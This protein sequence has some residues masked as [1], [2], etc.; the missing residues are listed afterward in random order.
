MLSNQV[1]G[2]SVPWWGSD[3]PSPAQGSIKVLWE[4]A[5]LAPLSGPYLFSA[6]SSHMPHLFSKR[7]LGLGPLA[8]PTWQSAL[9][10]HGMDA[11]MSQ[12]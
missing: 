1:P 11:C 5:P 3:S 6:G 10:R 12:L 2:F 4:E 7:P 9:L 8:L